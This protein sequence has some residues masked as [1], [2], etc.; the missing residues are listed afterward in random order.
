[1]REGLA[2]DRLPPTITD[3]DLLEG[4]VPRTRL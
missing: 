3:K 1:M 2:L 4:I